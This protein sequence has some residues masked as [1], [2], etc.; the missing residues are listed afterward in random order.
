MTSVSVLNT[1]VDAVN[2]SLVLNLKDLINKSDPAYAG[3]VR[4]GQLQDDPTNPGLIVLTQ[5]GDHVD[6]DRW[7]HGIVGGPGQQLPIHLD[8]F[9]I[10]CGEMWYRRFTTE[11]SQFWPQAFE[12]EE[13][14]IWAQVILSR[15]EDAIRKT[16]TNS[17]ADDFGESWVQTNMVMSRNVEQGGPG[18]FIWRAKIW[19][20]AMTNRN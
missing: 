2:D 18:Q 16:V 4:I 7:M 11:I 17:D 6:P 15:A 3:L 9:E 5:S 8:T 20:Q 12:R 10:G 1:I 13:A 19:W 14:R